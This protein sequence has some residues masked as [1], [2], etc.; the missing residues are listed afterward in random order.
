ME[1]DFKLVS[2]SLGVVTM[3]FS[4]ELEQLLFKA[5]MSVSKNFCKLMKDI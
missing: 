3:A 5:M 2:S 4:K 1:A